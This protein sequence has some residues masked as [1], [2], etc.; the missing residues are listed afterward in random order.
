MAQWGAFG[1]LLVGAIGVFWWGLRVSL[2][3]LQAGGEWRLVSEEEGPILGSLILTLWK[4]RN[5]FEDF[6]LL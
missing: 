5:L 4:L 2:V 1:G 6:S 3:G